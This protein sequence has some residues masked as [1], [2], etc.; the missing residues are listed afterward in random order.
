[1]NVCV[2]VCVC[3]SW[4]LLQRGDRRL[5]TQSRRGDPNRRGDPKPGPHDENGL[6]INKWFLV[7][8][9]TSGGDLKNLIIRVQSF[10]STANGFR[11]AW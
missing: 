2:C 3:V 9:V 6:K 7:C 1:M 10:K 4:F 5:E 11:Y 8:L